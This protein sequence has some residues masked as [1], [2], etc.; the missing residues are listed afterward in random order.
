MLLRERDWEWMRLNFTEEEKQEL[1]AAVTG[2]SI[3]PRGWI[4]DQSRCREVAKRI[5][6]FLTA[7][8]SFRAKE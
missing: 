1:R 7:L 6:G 4:I 3:C 8:P 5:I 2:E